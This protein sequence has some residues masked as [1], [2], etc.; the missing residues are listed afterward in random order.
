M[1]EIDMGTCPTTSGFMP[2]YEVSD[3]ELASAMGIQPF[4]RSKSFKQNSYIGK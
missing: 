2:N 1:I 3:G 4:A